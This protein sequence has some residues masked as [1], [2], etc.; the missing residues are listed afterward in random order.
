MNVDNAHEI[1]GHK[2]RNHKHLFDEQPIEFEFISLKQIY[3][4]ILILI[5]Q[6]RGLI[7]EIKRH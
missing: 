6:N 2:R 7:N 3:K 4:E 1:R 5:E